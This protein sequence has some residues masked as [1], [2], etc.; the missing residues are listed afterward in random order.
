M[1]DGGDGFGVVDDRGSAVEADDRGEGRLDARDAALAFERFHQRGFFAHFV[2]A[3]AGLRDDLEFGF[4]PED[5]FA[6]EALRVGIG[7]GLLH[8]LEEVAVFAAQVDEA[9]LG[10]DGEAGD[11]GSFNDGVRIV[12]EDQVVLAGAGLAFVAVDQ[13][14]LGLGRLLGHERPLQAGGKARA[15]AAAQIGGLHLVDDPVGALRQAF[16]RGFVAAEL[17]VLVDI[18]RALAE[19]TG[20]D[21]DFIGMRD[22]PRHSFSFR[23]GLRAILGKDAGNVV[24]G[25]LIVEG[26]VDLDGRRPAA[27]ADA[28]HFFEREDAVGRDALVANAEFVLEAFVEVRRRRAA[29]N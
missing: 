27:D 10:A 9:D 12:Q 13:N 4:G 15:A 20:H 26:V 18:G 17:D 25:Q 8:D 21:L 28:L 1:R 19:A 29:C 2:G 11:D 5:V 3:G 24:R 23:S 22:Q 16:L 14:V 7:D 6:E